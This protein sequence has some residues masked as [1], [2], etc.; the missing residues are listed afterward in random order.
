MGSACH[1]ACLLVFATDAMQRPW[2]LQQRRLV[3]ALC[4]LTSLP[5]WYLP[6]QN[7]ASSL[8]SSTA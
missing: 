3:C 7:L 8:S 5:T 2:V 1:H 6:E 4:F